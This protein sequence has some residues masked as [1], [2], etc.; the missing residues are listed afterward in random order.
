MTN[1]DEPVLQLMAEY[2]SGTISMDDEVRFYAW[3]DESE[4]HKRMFF[5]W[6]AIYDNCRMMGIVFDPKTSWQ[7]LA[8]KIDI[9]KKHKRRNLLV[10]ITAYAAVSLSIAISGFTLGRF[11]RGDVSQVYYSHYVT[12]TGDVSLL[13]L[14]DGTLVNVG[15]K[16]SIRYGTD[17]NRK[18][19]VV[20]LDGEAF[21]D[22]A[23]N[24]EKPFIVQVEGQA[25]EVLGTRFNVQAYSSDSLCMT[26]LQEG[27]VKLTFDHLSGDTYLQPDQMATFNRYAQ[28]VQI[29][30]V[31]ASLADSW[32][33]GDYHFQKEVLP[34]ILQRISLLYD[35]RFSILSDE[36]RQK[37]FTGTICRSQSV[38]EILD[39]I[40]L[41]LPAIDYHIHDNIIELKMRK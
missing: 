10:R 18:N 1:I 22:V 9:R 2:L 30:T 39:L 4:E 32:V 7:I 27:K 6:K 29:Q 26:T 14:P 28:K 5:E 40:R 36:I 37:T 20:Y 41:S 16:T 3:I 34:V 33:G 24:P 15:P 31:D 23:K 11:F 38:A 25:I 8:D 12:K 21:F 35:V 17:F 19:R 13:E